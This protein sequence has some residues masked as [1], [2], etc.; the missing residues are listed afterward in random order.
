[1]H[2]KKYR[3]LRVAVFFFVGLLVTISITRDNYLLTLVGMITG[4]VFMFLVRAKVKIEADERVQTIQEKAARMT[5]TIFAPT[6]GIA[7]LLL[8]LPS[9]SGMTVF[10]NGEWLYLESLGMIFAYLS[11]F[12]IVIYA[13]SYHFLNKRFGGAS[14][15]E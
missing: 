8:L 9:K 13:I 11:L 1:M 7:A 6:I 5:Y 4:M 2:T 15:E 10:S 3:Q 12:L 14:N